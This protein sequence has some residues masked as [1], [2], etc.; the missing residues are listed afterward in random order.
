M[1]NW[2]ETPNGLQRSFRF[3]DFSTAWAFMSRVALLAERM[4]HHPDWRNV[5]NTVEITLNTH[6]ADG[7]ITDKDRRLAAAIDTLVQ[8]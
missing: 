5:Y 6:D 3:A 7:A 8:P 1:H 2:T 4:G